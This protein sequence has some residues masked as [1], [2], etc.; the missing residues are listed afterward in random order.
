MASSALGIANT[1]T[2]AVLNGV[3]SNANQGTGSSE[4]IGQSESTGE[5][6]STSHTAGTEATNASW[7]MMKAANAFN[8]ESMQKQMEFNAAQA[9]LN[10]EWQERM[11]NTAVQRQVADLKAAGINPILAASLGGAA[12]PGGALASTSGI[13]SAIGQAHADQ[14][15]Q[16]SNSNQSSSSQKAW[17]KNETSS[18]LVNQLKEL[19]GWTV[20]LID[21]LFND[22]ST[23][24]KKA[25]QNTEK[26]IGEMDIE[27]K[28]VMDSKLEKLDK[29]KKGFGNGL[30][31]M[32]SLQDGSMAKEIRK[33]LIKQLEKTTK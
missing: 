8:R 27:L 26:A 1:I 30:S 20:D 3:L 13:S 10:R 11:A 19:T 9:V 33:D 32:Q 4:M 14:D 22:G 15:S 2:G 28:K 6:Q 16:S 24:S 25:S 31:Y 17:S 7:E 29:S 12:T 21:Q 23:S 5:G 18:N